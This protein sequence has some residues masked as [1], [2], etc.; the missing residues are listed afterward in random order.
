MLDVK[1]TYTFTD[2]NFQVK[3]LNL[4]IFTWTRL[5]LR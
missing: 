5:L 3:I 4:S 1:D 2:Q